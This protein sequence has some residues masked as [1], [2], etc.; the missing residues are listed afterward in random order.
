MLEKTDIKKC[1]D[2]AKMLLYS[3]IKIISI[4]KNNTIILHPI[5]SNAYWIDE[6]NM[7]MKNILEDKVAYNKAQKKYED[8]I[9]RITK[10]E[11]FTLYITNPYRLLFL[12][13]TK[14]YICLEDFS[15]ALIESWVE[16]ERTSNNKDVS[17]EE[18]VN[19]FKK[20]EKNI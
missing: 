16:G 4:D 12:K 19:Y 1:R 17:K 7:V 6:E 13:L 20:A 8:I 5:F 11:T 10:Y 14:D 3:G 2:V 15:K 18:L 9:D